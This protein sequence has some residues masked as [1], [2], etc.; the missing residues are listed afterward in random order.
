MELLSSNFRWFFRTKSADVSILDTPLPP[1]QQTSAFQTPLPPSKMLT[2]FM[3]SP[4]YDSNICSV[5]W[6][7]LDDEYVALASTRHIQVICKS[8]KYVSHINVV[9]KSYLCMTCQ[10]FLSSWGWKSF[11]SCLIRTKEVNF[12]KKLTK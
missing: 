10:F 7:F 8:C 9:W 5:H 6:T 2:Y 4:Y 12:L 1:C 3:D 11:Q